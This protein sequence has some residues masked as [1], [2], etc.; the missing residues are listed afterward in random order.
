M[1]RVATTV[2]VKKALSSNNV[3]S[4]PKKKKLPNVVGHW[5]DGIWVHHSEQGVKEAKRLQKAYSHQELE[6][7]LERNAQP[8]TFLTAHH[9]DRNPEQNQSNHQRLYS[10]LQARGYNPIPTTGHYTYQEGNQNQSSQEPSYLV[11]GM[12]TPEAI[13]LGHRYGQES[14]LTHEGLFNVGNKN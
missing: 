14:V 1:P 6:Q 7:L 11:P 3:T 9:K 5:E 2:P 13:E 8:W 10:D 4:I 12:S